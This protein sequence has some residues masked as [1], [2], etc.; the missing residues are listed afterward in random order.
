M[1]KK[2]IRDLDKS[3]A[4]FNWNYPKSSTITALSGSGNNWAFGYNINGNAAT[5]TIH[6]LMQKKIEPLDQFDGISSSMSLAGGTGSGLGTKLLTNVSDWYP[7]SF[8]ISHL[9]WPNRQG[10]VTVQSYNAI[11]TL[12]HLLAD[13]SISPDC[14]VN[15]SND[16][17][18]AICARRL[19]LDPKEIGIAQIN[20]LISHQMCG[21][22]LPRDTSGSSCYDNPL[23]NLVTSCCS[24]TLDHRMVR[25]RSVPYLD[26]SLE[27]FSC[28]T[29]SQLM[30]MSRQMMLNG[31]PID[32]YY[33]TFGK[34][35][36]KRR[37]QP[38]LNAAV[39]LRGFGANEYHSENINKITSDFQRFIDYKKGLTVESSNNS[40][41]GHPRSATFVTNGGGL[42]LS[43]NELTSTELHLD[44]NLL[45][46]EATFW[47]MSTTLRSLHNKAWCLFTAKAYLHHYAEFGIT[48]EHFLDCFA[49]V[50][51]TAHDYG[52]TGTM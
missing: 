10:E 31:A 33:Q 6:E 29:W 17:L 23:N 50:L 48:N 35:S 28:E 5:E 7:K 1:E 16:A 19:K 41:L 51:Q 32:D 20:H 40:L 22:Y 14:M 4:P 9:I 36:D 24:G 47:D 25:V 26:S 45:M 12:G 42:W 15:F 27:E 3:V 34:I 2:V 37:L 44:E 39:V 46:R 8:S 38:V 21:M 49:S 43:E 13:F 11:L 30:K 18:Q 52:I